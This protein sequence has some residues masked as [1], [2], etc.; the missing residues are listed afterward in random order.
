MSLYKQLWL[1]VTLLTTLAFSGSFLLTTKSAQNY[2]SEQLQLKN[3]D[4]ATSLALSLS[5]QNDPVLRELLISAQFDNSHYEFIKLIGPSGNS[6][7]EHNS[8]KKVLA[9]TWFMSLFPIEATAGIA[10]VTNG[11]QQI[12]TLSLKSDSRFAYHEMWVSTQLMFLY[13]LAG[14]L[15]S[16]LVGNRILKT[17]LKPLDDVINQAQ[18][19]GERR[20]ITIDEPNTREYRLLV[21][22]MNRLSDRVKQMLSSEGGKLHELHLEAERDQLTGLLNRTPFL[23]HLSSLLR[24]G[25]DLCNGCVVLLRIEQLIELNRSEGRD[26]M[27]SLLKNLG[28]SLRDLADQCEGSLSGRLNGSD[29]ILLL[30]GCDQPESTAQRVYEDFLRIAAQMHLSTTPVITAAGGGY[31]PEDTSQMLL[32]RLDAALASAETEHRSCLRMTVADSHPSPSYRTQDWKNLISKALDDGRVKLRET[33]IIISGGDV[34][35]MHLVPEIINED[36]SFINHEELSPWLSRLDLAAAVDLWCLERALEKIP[37]R[38]APSLTLSLSTQL[39]NSESEAQAF[40]TILNRN[41]AKAAQLRLGFPEYGA[42]Q[43][44]EN[45]KDLSAQLRTIGV[46]IGIEQVGPEI[47]SIGKLA[48]ISIDYVTVDEAVVHDIDNNGTRQI[49]LR[50]LCTIAHSI[51]LTTY[52]EGISTSRELEVIKKLGVDGATGAYF[53]NSI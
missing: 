35:S 4:N 5:Q 29:F 10:Q 45:L 44:L 7:I 26:V 9:P 17:I 12:G 3:F 6:L 39:L 52:A 49:F 43:H 51:G 16:G 36:G 8:D 33:P 25:D 1:A 2:L 27:D 34:Q 28:A 40:L 46:T 14:A 19:I 47:A 13:F 32:T 24:K 15:F 21:T 30:P 20:F 18:A 48:D 23:H 22:S 38:D 11:W 42:Y 41:P 53:R 31:Q 37:C 50:G